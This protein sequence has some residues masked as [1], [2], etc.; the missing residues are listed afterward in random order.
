MNILDFGMD[1]QAAISAP[2]VSFAEP[3]FLVVEREIPA[4]VFRALEA[5]G[6][7]VRPTGGLG[8]GHGLTIEWGPN[9]L[10]VRFTGGSDPRG[11]GSAK[12]W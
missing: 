2:R 11:T 4:S 12:G 8:N 7:T 6:H 5:L 9:G 3:N 1:I 10:P